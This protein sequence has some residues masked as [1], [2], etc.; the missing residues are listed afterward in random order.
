[1]PPFVTICTYLQAADRG[2][3]TLHDTFIAIYS[4]TLCK[5]DLQIF[6]LLLYNII[7]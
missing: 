4:F 2:Q 3:P 5:L 7:D 1:M 6:S